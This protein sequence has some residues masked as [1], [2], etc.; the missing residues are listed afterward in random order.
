M[1]G[2]T[3]TQEIQPASLSAAKRASL[4]AAKSL[5]FAA[6][7]DIAL[8][9]NYTTAVLRRRVQAYFDAAGENDRDTAIRL[10]RSTLTA[11]AKYCIGYEKLGRAIGCIM[12]EYWRRG[13]VGYPHITPVIRAESRRGDGEN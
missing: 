5:N 4:S 9:H 3:M 8:F 1:E 7:G 13:N 12:R 11:A 2:T 10:L 6:W